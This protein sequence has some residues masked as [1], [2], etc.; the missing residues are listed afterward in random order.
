MGKVLYKKWIQSLLLV[1]DSKEDYLY[2][3]VEFQ[4]HVGKL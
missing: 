3:V 1:N 4:W 2:T